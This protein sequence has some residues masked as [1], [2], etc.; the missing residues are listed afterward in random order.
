MKEK[1]LIGENIRD[2]CNM[3]G[4]S[5]VEFLDVI[6]DFV[7]KQCSK[8]AFVFTPDVTPQY[9]KDLYAAGYHGPEDGGP[10]KGWKKNI[11]FLKPALQLLPSGPLHILD[12]GTGQDL[13][14]DALRKLGHKVTA[15]DIAPP[16]RPHPDRLTGD[17]LEL[18]LKA[19]QFDL[20]YA[21]QVFE[22]LPDPHSILEELLKLLKPEGLLLI[23][24]DMETE[25]RLDNEFRD[26]W[27]VAPPDH[28]SFYRPQT[29]EMAVKNTGNEV[30]I[31]EPTFVVIQKQRGSL[32]GEV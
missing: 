3:C 30:L 28:C 2:H 5:E 31:S 11:S 1:Q 17:I 8:C 18:N 15:V 27:Y 6:Q 13:A 20:V 25:A 9:L 32:E 24:T 7:F 23:H 12:F 29:F 22:H 4:S 19:E 26:W 16:I 14:P 21:F 10:K